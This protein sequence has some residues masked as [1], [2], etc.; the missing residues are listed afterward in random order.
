MK[1]G[2]EL[3]NKLLKHLLL[4]TL[5]NSLGILL[6]DGTMVKVENRSPSYNRNLT[7]TALS[8]TEKN[9]RMDMNDRVL[10]E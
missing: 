8:I 7:K 1:N 3:V 4:I 2:I 5:R 9:C 6:V 10:N